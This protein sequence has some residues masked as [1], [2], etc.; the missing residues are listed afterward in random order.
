[1]EGMVTYESISH[2]LMICDREYS[3]KA[4]DRKGGVGTEAQIIS[5]EIYGKTNQDKFI[6]VIAEVDDEGN[7]YVLTFVKTRIHIDLSTPEKYYENYDQLLRAFY[8]RPLFQKP[9]LGPVPKRIFEDA[10]HHPSA[11]PKYRACVQA[12][13]QASKAAPRL[14]RKGAGP[15]A[16]PGLD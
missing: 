12:V 15:G 11:A 16:G 7:P 8:N 9:K 13:R 1:M 2:V 14:L 4:D 10:G 3:E 6:P 5:P